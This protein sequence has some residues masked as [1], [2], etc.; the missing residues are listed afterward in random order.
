MTKP[1]AFAMLAYPI[2]GGGVWLALWLVLRSRPTDATGAPLPMSMAEMG[3]WAIVAVITLAVVAVVE[4]QSP[5]S[6]PWV[7]AWNCFTDLLLGYL[8]FE[9]IRQRRKSEGAASVR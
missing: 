4:A 1:I 7:W 8:V 2:L 5:S 3:G 9:T 6:S